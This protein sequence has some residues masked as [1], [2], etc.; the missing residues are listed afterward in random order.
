MNE[1]RYQLP[2]CHQNLVEMQLNRFSITPKLSISSKDDSNT[3][4]SSLVSSSEDDCTTIE[5]ALG[6]DLVPYG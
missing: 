3:D 2:L 5:F 6:L 4:G 1:Y